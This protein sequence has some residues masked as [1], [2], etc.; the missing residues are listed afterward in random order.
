MTRPRGY[1][2]PE[3]LTASSHLLQPDK[4]RSY[5][6]MQ[7][8][9]GQQVLDVGCGPGTDTLVL[10]GL[11]GPQGRVVGVDHDAA[12]LAE[13]DERARQA[14]LTQRVRHQQA[15]ATALPFSSDQFDACRS[16][17]LFQH[18]HEPAAAL[19][20]MVRVTKPGG[21]IVVL[22]TDWGTFS[23]DTV[24][25]ELEGRWNR[26]YAERHLH[27]GFSGRTLYRLFKQQGLVD[28]VVE[29]RPLA[30][31]SWPATRYGSSWDVRAQAVVADGVMTEGEV[32]RLERSFE[33]A[34]ATGVF[35]ASFSLMLVAGTK[36]P[37]A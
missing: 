19:R 23:M 20:E 36:P 25:R 33:A 32:L 8:G 22:D 27:N 7:L 17:R 16:E 9:P 4:Q 26:Y 24:E 29:M 35:F 13:A 5:A 6:V 31:T 10:A 34:E 15:D 2:D 37:G 14:G 11:V 3:Y 28:V 18:L 30:L 21:R 1:V 12:M